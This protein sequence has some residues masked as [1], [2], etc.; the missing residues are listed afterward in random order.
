MTRGISNTIF[1][2][3]TGPLHRW[4]HPAGFV[5]GVGGGHSENS[6]RPGSPEEASDPPGRPYRGS[7]SH[8]GPRGGRLAG[9][10]NPPTETDES[11]S[12]SKDLKRRGFRFLGPTVCYAFMQATGMVNGHVA[13]CF[14][15]EE[16]RDAT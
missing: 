10:E 13:S 7:P 9:G 16:L 8:G 12:M 14:R 11:R 3:S 2:V 15:W 6:R 5:G 4:R 1:V